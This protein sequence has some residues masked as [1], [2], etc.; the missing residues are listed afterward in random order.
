MYYSSHGSMQKYCHSSQRMNEC[1]VYASHLCYSDCS[2]S[3]VRALLCYTLVRK[4]T[5]RLVLCIQVSLSIQLLDQSAI[6]NNLV[7]EACQHSH[8]QVGMKN[9]SALS[10]GCT[11]S[12]W[13]GELDRTVGQAW[14]VRV[15]C[16][17]D[18]NGCPWTSIGQVDWPQD[19]ETSLVTEGGMSNGHPVDI[20]WTG[21][22]DKPSQ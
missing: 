16:P 10:N 1:R 4:A 2:F 11:T 20:H 6:L 15:G 8:Y 19:S 21:Q 14:S 18:V 9:L 22:W 7:R 17:M 3:F 12:H 13:T 5:Q